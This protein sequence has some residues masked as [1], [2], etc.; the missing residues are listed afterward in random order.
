MEEI[1]GRS[2]GGIVLCCVVCVASEVRKMW[3]DAMFVGFVSNI[4][5]VLQFSQ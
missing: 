1:I 4:G 2:T 5:V 3:L